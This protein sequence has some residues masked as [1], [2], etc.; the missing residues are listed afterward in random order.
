MTRYDFWKGFNQ[1][2]SF[3]PISFTL[4]TFLAAYDFTRE[5]QLCL[6]F[7]FSLSQYSWCS[8][9]ARIFSTSKT[10]CSLKIFGHHFPSI[11]M[12]LH[13]I[14]IYLNPSYH[15]DLCSNFSHSVIFYGHSSQRILL[16]QF[17]YLSLPYNY[18]ICFSSEYL[19]LFSFFLLLYWGRVASALLHLL[20]LYWLW[21]SLWQHGTQQNVENS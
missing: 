17:F 9:Y 18:S 8:V 7:Y 10:H 20:L 1:V 5:N 13:W 12:Y 19:S 16:P 2:S 11:W 14:F 4:C 15:P 21:Q 6:H 3:W